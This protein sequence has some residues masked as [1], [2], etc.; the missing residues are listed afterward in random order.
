MHNSVMYAFNPTCCG[1]NLQG[2][3]N[4]IALKHTA[5]EI[6][7]NKHTFVVVQILQDFTGFGLKSVR[8]CNIMLVK[9]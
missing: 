2:G 8:K 1:C 3:N 5:I 9:D 6:G 7:H 4:N